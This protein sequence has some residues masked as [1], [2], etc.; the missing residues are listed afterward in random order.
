VNPGDDGYR[1]SAVDSDG[2]RR[3]KRHGEIGSAAR[4]RLNRGSARGDRTD[5]A[6]IGE[7]LG[8]QQLLGDVLGRVADPRDLYKAH[9]CGFKRPLRGDRRCR[10]GEAR[11][12]SQ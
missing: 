11:G 7:P 3:C 5:I 10:A 12:S 8:L 1:C 9:R 2:E 4:D 6:D